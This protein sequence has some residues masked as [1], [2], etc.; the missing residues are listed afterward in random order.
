[1]SKLQVR[2]NKIDSIGLLIMQTS[3]LGKAILIFFIMK[4][5]RQF[6]E[7]KKERNSK[8]LAH[9]GPGDK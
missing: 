3:T 5:F 9:L 1:M 4:Y 8:M 2:T 6:K 7:R